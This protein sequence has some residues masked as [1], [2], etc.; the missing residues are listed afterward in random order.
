MD[1]TSYLFS[2]EANLVWIMDSIDQANSGELIEIELPVSINSIR[3]E[4]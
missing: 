4:K 2:A 3:Y 1:E